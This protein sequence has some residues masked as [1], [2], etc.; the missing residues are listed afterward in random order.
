[1]EDSAGMDRLR[2]AGMRGL[3]VVS[4][5]DRSVFG[6]D[7]AQVAQLVGLTYDA[8]PVLSPTELIARYHRVLDVAVRFAEQIPDAHLDDKLPHRDRSYLTLVNHLVQIA[9]DFLLVAAGKDLIGRL[10]ES[11]PDANASVQA[12]GARSVG[13]KAEL[14]HWLE[15]VGEADLARS[16]TTYFGEQTLHQVLERAVWHS[17]QHARQL[18]MVLGLLDITPLTPLTAEDLADLPMPEHVWDG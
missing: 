13:L 3:P 8:T 12:L 4:R 6:V 17:A 7:L 9:A 11:V 15:Q 1:V 2:A 5:G 10:A 16:V 18:M 14:T